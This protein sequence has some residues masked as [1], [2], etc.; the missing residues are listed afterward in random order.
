MDIIKKFLKKEI[1]RYIVAGAC[2][3]AVNLISFYLL[4]L[5]SDLSRSK[6]SVIAISLSIVFA[7]FVNKFFVFVSEKKNIGIII[8]EFCAFVGMR[9]FAMLVE[10]IGTN[11]LCDSFRY[12]EFISK[13]LIQFV[14]VVINYVFGKC[15]VFKKNKRSIR[16]LLSDHYIVLISGAIP[17]VFMLGV[18]IFEKIGPFG[19]NSITMVDSLHQYLPFFSDYYDKLMNEGSMFYTWHVGLGSNFL[20][21]ISYY[22]ASPMN[23]I[24]VLFDKKHLYIAMCLLI[25]IKIVLSGASFAYYLGCKCKDKHH[26]GIVIFAVAYALSNFVI[27][28]SWNLMWMDCIMIL[29]LI[30]AGFD[31]LMEN[32]EYKLYVWSLFYALL[33]NYYIAFMICIFLVLQFFL[34]NHHKIK[35]FFIDGLKFAGS[36]LLSAGMA[37]FLLVPAY[38]GINTTASAKRVLPEANWYGSFWDL[39]KQMFFLTKP[40]KSQQFDGGVNLYCGTFCMILF[41]V[42]FLNKKIQLL[43]KIRNVLLLI[44][45]M[46][47]FNN[48]LLNYIWHGFHNQYG[49]P[50]RFSF[51]FIFLLLT[52][53]YEALKNLD[54]EDI[55]C[56]YLS[57]AFACVFLIVA[58]KQIGFEKE[59]I[60]GTEIFMILYA[61]L[62]IVYKLVKGFLKQI[63]LCALVTACLVE[64]IFNG[65]KG[66]DSNG[67]VN[68]SQYFSQEESM[69][70]AIDYLDVDD[71]GDRVE[72]MRT[73][74]VDE[75]TYYNLKNATV[76]GSTVSNDLVNVMHRLGYYTGANEFLFDGG[77]TVSNAILGIRYLLKRDTDY[78]YFDV[79]YLERIQDVEIYENPYALS[80][81]F[82][83]NEDLLTWK[84]NEGTVFDSLNSFMSSATGITGIFSQLYP[85][86]SAYSDNCV[87]THDGDMSEYYSYTRT[88]SERCSFR[89][90]FDITEESNDLYIFANSSGINKIRIYIND[91][92]VNYA[93]LQN[94]TYHVG[95]LVK[96]Q[97]VT[98]EYCFNATQANQGSAR[99]VVADL[100]WN[101][102]LQ[103]YDILKNRQMHV[104]VFEDGYVKGYIELSESGLLFTSIPYDAGWTVYVDGKET[105][106]EKI[107]DAFIAV[108]LDAGEHVIEFSY[109]P[110]GLK[111]GLSIT[112][113]CWL[114]FALLIALGKREKR[115][116]LEAG[117]DLDKHL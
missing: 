10:V 75:P 105:T 94:Q 93:R 11:L 67:V 30:M 95:H 88:E 52:M 42:Y 39:I 81:G 115:K 47:S 61:V 73:T 116:K 87:I 5:F 45:L 70:A 21:I 109:Y 100:N 34:T 72:L 9:L 24:V 57:I 46:I 83:V 43:D 27:G 17:A 79:N 54:K 50:N 102:F 59:I 20:S 66:Y 28:Y 86:V 107:A 14:V 103:A 108:H 13:I 68:I 6:A 16:K 1:V 41:F 69:E 80:T 53:G 29:P 58:N 63:L 85:E 55:I 18:W 38:L 37:A 36:S 23:F 60:V 3:T 22:L 48:E 71:K 84:G 91:Q 104:G 2:T 40:I 51:L 8:K 113:L 64:T 98:V 32:G 111:I 110:P 26:F 44:F 12:N 96:G 4:R 15:F 56:I 7:F 74:I 65:I 114:F 99:L 92:E 112:I 49:I 62:L 25:S 78:N 76:F 117:I 77:N 31:K 97:T 101:A 89:L 106:V 19:S 33:C 35:K 90:S 82:M